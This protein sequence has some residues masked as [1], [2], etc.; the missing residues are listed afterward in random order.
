[1]LTPQVFR[2]F[3]PKVAGAGTPTSSRIDNGL[4]TRV[5]VRQSFSGINRL[6]SRSSQH[7]AATLAAHFKR[8]IETAPR[9]E[10]SFESHN[11]PP[12][13][14]CNLESADLTSAL[15]RQSAVTWSEE[16][17]SP[18]VVTFSLFLKVLEKGVRE[19][20]APLSIEGATRYLS[21]LGGY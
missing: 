3:G 6:N 9:Q 2:P 11:A 15:G 4:L 21:G 5:P 20:P 18:L 1:M 16:T 13:R 8:P 12:N 17:G 7:S 10:F 19:I 14:V